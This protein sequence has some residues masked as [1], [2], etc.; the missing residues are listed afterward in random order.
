M[1]EELFL[2]FSFLRSVLKNQTELALENLALR[3]QL[4]ILKR[5]RYYHKYR[6]HL[7]LDKDAPEP[8]PIQAIS[9]GEVI[10][11]PEVGGLHHHYERRAA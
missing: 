4:A 1:M 9:L 11:I 8:R 6:T 2:L 5:N 10:E 7:S 3:Q